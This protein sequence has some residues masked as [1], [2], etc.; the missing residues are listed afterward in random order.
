MA[1]FGY[2]VAFLPE[3]AADVISAVRGMD[4][5]TPMELEMLLMISVERNAELIS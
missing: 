2:L 1:F 4:R 3:R 5:I